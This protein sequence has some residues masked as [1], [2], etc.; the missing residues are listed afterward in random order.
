M[1][2]GTEPQFHA[3]KR[4]GNRNAVFKP[5][6]GKPFEMSKPK[7]NQMFHENDH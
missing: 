2:P 7:T 5:E 3:G 6:A 1:S 4:R